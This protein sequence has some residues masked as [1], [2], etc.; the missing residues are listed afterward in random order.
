MD[1]FPSFYKKHEVAQKKK[2]KGRLEKR[3]YTSFAV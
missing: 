3:R 1:L 2:K